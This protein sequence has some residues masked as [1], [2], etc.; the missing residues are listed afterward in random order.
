MYDFIDFAMQE[1]HRTIGWRDRSYYARLGAKADDVLR[2]RIPTGLSLLM[3][4]PI[5]PYLQSFY[6]VGLPDKRSIGFMYSSVPLELQSMGLV[7]KEGR[8]DA[9]QGAFKHPKIL[10]GRLFEDL[11]LEAY[12]GHQLGR[13]TMLRVSALSDWPMESELSNVIHLFYY[14]IKLFC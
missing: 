11:R 10:F 13:N 5:S 8:Q 4:K 7:D 9:P 3:G 12:Y 6:S 14:Y 1:F 2:F